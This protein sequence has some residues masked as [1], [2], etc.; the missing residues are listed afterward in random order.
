MET[1][2][3]TMGYLFVNMHMEQRAECSLYKVSIF[4]KLGEIQSSQPELIELECEIEEEFGM[5]HSF[6]HEFDTECKNHGVKEAD[7]NLIQRHVTMPLTSTV[8]RKWHIQRGGDIAVNDW[9]VE[10]DTLKDFMANL[11]R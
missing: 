6:R 4:G 10:I 5:Q 3:R 7:I 1:F 11:A 2:G 8:V 9:R